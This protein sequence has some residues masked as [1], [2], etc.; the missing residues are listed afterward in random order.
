MSS[1]MLIL[2]VYNISLLYFIMGRGST[3]PT[4][5]NM[6]AFINRICKLTVNSKFM[7]EEIKK[8]LPLNFSSLRCLADPYY[9]IHRITFKWKMAMKDENLNS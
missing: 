4:F 1:E 9:N 2:L 8:I 7:T 3:L 5:Y 6:N